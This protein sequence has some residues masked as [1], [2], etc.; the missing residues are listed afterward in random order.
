MSVDR[1]EANIVNPKETRKKVL[2]STILQ[3]CPQLLS[4]SPNERVE[5]SD[6]SLSESHKP[7]NV[8]LSDYVRKPSSHHHEYLF[9]KCHENV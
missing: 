4:E 6:S 1:S 8:K 7:T 3:K 9:G 5:I 2:N